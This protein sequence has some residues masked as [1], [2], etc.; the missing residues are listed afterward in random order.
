MSVK[1]SRNMEIVTQA[2][3]ISKKLELNKKPS[4]TDKRKD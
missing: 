3:N 2:R 4:R 1:R